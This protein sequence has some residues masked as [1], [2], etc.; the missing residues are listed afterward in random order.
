EENTPFGFAEEL[1]E[2]VEEEP[3]WLDDEP[4][5]DSKSDSEPVPRL[6]PVPLKLRPKTPAGQTELSFDAGP[7]GRFEG[8][9]PNLVDGDDL[10]I[11]PFLR[12][13]R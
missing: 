6:E 2:L 4:E 7:R 12:K 11:P 3:E 10:D 9:S 1:D 13:K 5:S 8:E